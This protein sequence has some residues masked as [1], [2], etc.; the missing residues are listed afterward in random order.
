MNRI[1]SFATPNP[2][3]P[4]PRG[5][6]AE[7]LANRSA[8]SVIAPQ[9]PRPAELLA[10]VTIDN[11]GAYLSGFDLA[12]HELLISRAYEEDRTMSASSYEIPIAECLRFLG[13]DVRQDAVR[14]SLDKM[15]TILLSFVGE[16]G[17]AF[18][19]VQ[20]LTYWEA[21]MDAETLIGY[22]FPDPIRWLMRH[23]PT[24]YG[25]IELHALGKG[26]MRSKYSHMLYKRI[27]LEVARRPWME[28]ADNR[29]TLSF[30]PDELA[31]VVDF[32]KIKGAVP[33]GKLNE[34]VISKV[35]DDFAG[36]RKFDTRIT[37]NGGDLAPKKGAPVQTVDFTIK[38]HRDSHHTVHADTVPLQDA[39][40]KIGA[41]D[42][43]RFR[44][45]SVFWLRVPQKFKALGIG[46]RHAHAAWLVALQEALDA[47]PLTPLYQ[48]RRYRG[49]NLLSAISADGVEAAAWG[50]FSEEAD[51]GSDICG[52]IHVEKKIGPAH[53][54]RLKRLSKKPSVKSGKR[55]VEKP[56][57][58]KAPDRPTFET[59]TH[60]DIEIDHAVSAADLDDYVHA[61][62][63]RET[64]NGDRK[65]R[66][67]AYYRVPGTTVRQHFGFWIS[68]ADE[69]ELLSALSR[70]DKWMTD[71]PTYRI[72]D[73]DA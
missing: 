61:T 8:L 70:L 46:H 48:K 18:R 49:Q 29:F 12:L 51:E 33:F 52:S 53:A 22:Q 3:Q 1:K 60:V 38:V 5:S 41:P 19:A 44:I 16:N 17:K 25:Y 43:P 6:T 21:I 30:T 64:W 9:S 31:T 50:F 69:N 67:R 10:G 23:M 58:V 15:K 27:A 32:P 39:G 37:Y 2:F 35:I 71:T 42:E 54:A 7:A 62:I 57:A 13:P 45:N 11:A 59:C 14:K 4:M 34:R 24:S 72:E 47:D 73:K 28:G 55:A 36:V 63:S 68:P 66:L 26:S 40:R 65:V 56:K 20:M